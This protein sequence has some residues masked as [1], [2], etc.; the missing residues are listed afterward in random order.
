MR[1]GAGM[2]GKVCSTLGA[3]LPN[4]LTSIAAEGLGIENMQNSMIADTADEMV[5]AILNLYNNQKLWEIISSSG[6]K[7]I[8]K[9]NGAYSSHQKLKAILHTLNIKTFESSRPINLYK[10]SWMN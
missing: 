6:I 1:F 8:D 10:D 2:K 3:G 7:H 9:L 4:V 5:I